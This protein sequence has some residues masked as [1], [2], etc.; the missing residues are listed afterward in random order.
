M[1]ITARVNQCTTEWSCQSLLI[2]EFADTNLCVNMT[3]CKISYP[4]NH[5]PTNRVMS[6]N[7][8]TYLSLSL[9]KNIILLLG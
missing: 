6:E 3:G 4:A 5:F 8:A 7:T 9:F 1:T 2:S